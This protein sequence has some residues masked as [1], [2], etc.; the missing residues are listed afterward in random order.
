MN[1]RLFGPV[2]LLFIVTAGLGFAQQSKQ[3]SPPVAL[4]QELK[5]INDISDLES[6]M[7]LD[8]VL[9]S[10][11]KGYELRDELDE[12]PRSQSQR[13]RKIEAWG[14]WSGD[15]YAGELVFEEGKLRM[16]TKRIW[17]P[18][19][20]ETELVDRIFTSIYDKS[21]HSKIE[22]EPGGDI[23]RTRDS[24]AILESQETSLGN[25]RKRTLKILLGAK[26]FNLSLTTDTD[27]S[28]YVTFDEVLGQPQSPPQQPKTSDK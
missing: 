15:R 22:E 21:G 28:R 24:A 23:T 2:N 19:H 6:G 1:L 20:G 7:P 18:G 16:A 26:L 13:P 27:G 17:S 4:K 12:F 9:A 5:P 11:R 14:V 10:L 8:R 3:P 25:L